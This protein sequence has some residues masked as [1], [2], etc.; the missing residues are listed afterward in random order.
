MTLSEFL[1]EHKDAKIEVYEYGRPL[2]LFNNEKIKD[3]ENFIRADEK[4][5]LINSLLYE[6]GGSAYESDCELCTFAIFRDDMRV[7][8][9]LMEQI[10]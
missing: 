8:C 3:Y 2:A 9:K 1:N 10:K 7:G 4:K 5:N 6:C